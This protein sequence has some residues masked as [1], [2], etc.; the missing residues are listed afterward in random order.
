MH[1]GHYERRSKACIV[2][3]GDEFGRSIGSLRNSSACILWHASIHRHLWHHGLRP[4]WSWEDVFLTNEV[5]H[6]YVFNMNA[7]NARLFVSIWE[8]LTD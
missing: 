1:S 8:R 2:I 4:N 3:V 7:Q 6:T 5:L